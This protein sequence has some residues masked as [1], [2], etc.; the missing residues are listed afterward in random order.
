MTARYLDLIEAQEQSCWILV[1]VWFPISSGHEVFPVHG[2]SLTFVGPMARYCNGWKRIGQIHWDSPK[3]GFP[4]QPSP[5]QWKSRHMFY[6]LYASRYLLSNFTQNTVMLICLTLTWNTAWER[7]D[8]A[9]AS[10]GCWVLFLLPNCSMCSNSSAV[11]GWNIP[12]R[13]ILI[14][15]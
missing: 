3:H 8:S 10:V 7:D 9:L 6:M 4:S 5:N 11:L 2:I 13:N 12:H 1:Y 14:F 15:S